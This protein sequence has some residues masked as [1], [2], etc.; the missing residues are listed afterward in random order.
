V[1]IGTT[2]PNASALLDL[3]ST[4]QGFLPPS[5]TSTQRNAITSPAAGLVVYNNTDHRL[6]IRQNTTWRSL[7]TLDGTETLTNKT[8]T[9]PTIAS[10]SSQWP[11]S[12]SI[13]PTTHGTSKR[14][15]I[16]IDGWS[17]LQDIVGDGTKNFGIVQTVLGSPTT[18]PVRLFINTTGNMGLGTTS[19]TTALHIQNNNSIGAGNPASNTVP[20]IYLFNDN[21]ASS[22]AHSI[23]A[24]RT[25]G[26]AGGKPYLSLDALN[27]VGYSIGLDNPNNRLLINSTWNFDMSNSLNNIVTINEV[28]NNR[29]EV[30]A[31]NTAATRDWPNGWGGGFTT[32]DISCAGIYYSTLTARS[33]VRL[34]NSIKDVDETAV[35]K[36]MKLRPVN[37]YWNEGKSSDIN[38]QYGL[39]AQEV[40]K[41]FPEMVFTASDS[42]QTKSVNYQALH[43]IS[44]KVIQ[45]QH[46]EI[47]NLKKNQKDLEDR[48][49][50][51]ERK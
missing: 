28:G 1:G 11:S 20:G 19:P 22:T 30:S 33:D 29:V 4:T 21:N 31:S 35:N 7:A 23:L 46:A 48:L 49:R 27:H 14:A 2:S 17:L 3:T 37:Y 13:T 15:S 18:Y 12:L 41:I 16:W 24:L 47:E 26:S 39:I 10:G 50:K 51:L 25:G 40:E 42:M 8:L 9:T 34:K 38:L 5:M 43:S 32:Y 44:M 45:S 36:Y 6:D